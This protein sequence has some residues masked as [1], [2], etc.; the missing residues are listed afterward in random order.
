MLAVTLALGRTHEPEA[1]ADLTD[2][3]VL[4]E[5]SPGFGRPALAD[6]NER[7]V[8]L[9]LFGIL[10]SHGPRQFIAVRPEGRCLRAGHFRRAQ[11]FQF[12]SSVQRRPRFWGNSR[13]LQDCLDD[14]MRR[15]ARNLPSNRG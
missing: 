14:T 3:K 7:R 15:L 12:L 5:V 13:V 11:D 2:L 10:K 6:K 9:L 8:Q 4:V 1:E